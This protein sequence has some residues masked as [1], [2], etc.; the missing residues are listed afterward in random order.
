[1]FAIELPAASAP[2]DAAASG[3]H[4]ALRVPGS[5]AHHILLVEDEPGVCKAMTKLFRVEGYRVTAAS[6]AVE[7]LGKL[8]K[9]FDLLVTDYHLENG[10]TGTEVINAIRALH[11][12]DFRAILVTGDSSAAVRDLQADANLRITRKPINSDEL[13][14]QV[15]ALLPA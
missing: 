4:A 1:V 6:S 12:A 5:V 8:N 14:A 10:R 7:A 13:L 9:R 2:S 3:T 15:R 11:G